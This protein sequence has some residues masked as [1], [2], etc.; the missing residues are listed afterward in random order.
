MQCFHTLYP[1]TTKQ[2]PDINHQPTAIVR[3]RRTRPNS[4]ASR[5]GSRVEPWPMVFE[6]AKETE[7]CGNILG[8]LG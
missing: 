1:P 7:Y 8:G 5:A 4:L 6:F 2:V 3:I